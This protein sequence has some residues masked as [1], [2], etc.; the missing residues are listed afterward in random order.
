VP[1]TGLAPEHEHAL[2]RIA[3][4]AVSNAM[5][6]GHPQHVRI[7]LVGEASH[8]VLSVADDGQGMEASPEDCAQH[9]F[10]LTNMRERAEAI[11][12]IWNIETTRGDGTRVCVR[13][14][15]RNIP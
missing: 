15:R 9:G 1:A 4:E 7:S 12:G 8:W 10:G 6:H 2:L 3:Q 11:G 14:P 5:R 13:L